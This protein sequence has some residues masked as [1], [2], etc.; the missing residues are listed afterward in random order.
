MKKTILLSALV[1]SFASSAFAQEV[2]FDFLTRENY[3][4]EPGVRRVQVKE[5]AP[6]EA[7]T[8]EGPATVFKLDTM[9]DEGL[10]LTCPHNDDQGY[11][12]VK[13]VKFYTPRQPAKFLREFLNRKSC[14]DIAEDLRFVT[15]DLNCL[16]TLKFSRVRLKTQSGQFWAKTDCRF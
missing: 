11:I 2:F 9:P 15:E 12:T 16:M 7:Q 8:E 6:T 14:L 3:I 1:L 4:I 13:G 5:L 10:E